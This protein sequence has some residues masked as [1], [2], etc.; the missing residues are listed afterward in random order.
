VP[1]STWDEVA[2]PR[3]P[4]A[5]WTGRDVRELALHYDTVERHGWYANLDPTLDAVA[6]FLKDGDLLLDYSGGTGIFA[7]RLLARLDAGA[8]PRAVGIALVDS[9]PKFLR[10]ALE[11]LGGEPRVGFRR[12][13]YLRSRG[14]LE[15]LQEALEPELLD[16][17]FDALVST[18]AI[19][20][21]DRLR[22]TLRSWRRALRPG[23][24][25]F[26]QSGNI[27]NPEIEPD[28]VI[29]DETVEAI[30]ESARRMVAEEERW[31]RY[32]P[33]L[34]DPDFME[35]HREFRRRVFPA[36][37]PL[38][39][40]LDALEGAGFRVLSV[41]R[42]SIPARIDEWHEFLAAY[43]AGVLGWIGGAEKVTGEPP[44][45]EAVRDRRE[46]MREALDRVFDGAGRF[47]ACWTYVT[48]E[49]DPTAS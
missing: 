22:E 48:A 46:I 32:R 41:E 39:H 34:E 37:R 29:I 31:S 16:R 33:R 2:A 18:N 30:H 15:T 27:R 40:Y 35:A 24:R 28:E 17:G 19:H 3:V 26:V 13:G 42:A 1:R 25:A 23:A 9:S 8:G 6:R 43:H 12:L 49:P 36:V 38:F 10:L 20:L 4:D 5:S 11:K 47:R 44:S 45:E 14:R 7:E 21:Y